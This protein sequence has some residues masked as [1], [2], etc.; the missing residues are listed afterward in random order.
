MN[1]FNR[2]SYTYINYRIGKKIYYNNRL[3]GICIFEKECAYL[4]NREKPKFYSYGKNKKKLQND[5]YFYR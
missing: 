5:N 1:S 3:Q 4:Q 2:L